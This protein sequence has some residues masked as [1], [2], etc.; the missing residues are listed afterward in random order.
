[1]RNHAFYSSVRL[2]AALLLALLA[3][4]CATAVSLMEVDPAKQAVVIGK[5]EGYVLGPETLGVYSHPSSPTMTADNFYLVDRHTQERFPL[6]LSREGFFQRTVPPG[7][8]LLGRADK[9]S[10]GKVCWRYLFGLVTAAPGELL[11]L[12]TLRMRG[13]MAKEEMYQGASSQ[14]GGTWSR[15]TFIFIFSY[16]ED[17]ASWADPLA[18]FTASQEGGTAGWKVMDVDLLRG[19]SFPHPQGAVEGPRLPLSPLAGQ[20]LA[21]EP[22]R[23]LT[24][25]FL[26]DDPA[27]A[28]SAMKKLSLQPESPIHG[29]EVEGMTPFLTACLMGAPKVVK[30]FLDQGAFPNPKVDVHFETGVNRN[31]GP[32]YLA[33]EGM[34]G[35]SDEEAKRYT[36][37]VTVLLEGGADPV[38]TASYQNLK[39]GRNGSFT[40]LD[41]ARRLTQD[42]ERFR[43]LLEKLKEYAPPEPERKVSPR[44][45]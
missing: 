14:G 13:E 27:K 37:T 12:G 11:D 17:E 42:N 38:S 9:D 23:L 19:R 5:V 10:M 16:P 3:A 18:R 40:L 36:E 29:W 41:F 15:G 43:P 24:R 39:T 30:A 22:Y 6:G 25:V 31:V 2:P 20:L 33:L 45:G 32:I 4:S 8:Y 26:R 7:E 44:A 28:A 34:G 1:M 21:Q 35:G